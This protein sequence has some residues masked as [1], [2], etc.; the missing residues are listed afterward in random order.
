MKSHLFVYITIH[1]IPMYMKFIVKLVMSTFHSGN[2]PRK[3]ICHH[4]IERACRY[5]KKKCKFDHSYSVPYM[6]CINLNDDWY[7]M[8][9]VNERIEFAFSQPEKNTVVVAPRIVVNINGLFT[10]S[11]SVSVD[12]WN[13]SGIHFPAS[14]LA[15]L[16]LNVPIDKVQNPNASADAW[17]KH[18][19]NEFFL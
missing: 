16:F 13:R 4:N 19:F 11:I 10:P 5:D 2:V 14:M 17:Y 18:R 6:W 1:D 15:S 12:A 3:P 7:P 8:E 9:D